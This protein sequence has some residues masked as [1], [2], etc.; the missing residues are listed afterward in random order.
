MESEKFQQE[1]LFQKLNTLVENLDDQKGTVKQTIGC[2]TGRVMVGKHVKRIKNLKKINKQ[3]HALKNKSY[4]Q[5]VSD[6]YQNRQTDQ[7]N[8]KVSSENNIW[9]PAP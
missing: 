5:T 7:W 1:F 3:W 2:S 4:F 6:W 9:L 8:R